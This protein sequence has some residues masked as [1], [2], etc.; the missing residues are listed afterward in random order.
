MVELTTKTL[1]EAGRAVGRL[2]KTIEGDERLDKIAAPVSDF[3]Q[4]LIPPGPV[5]DLLHGTPL[6]HPAHPF[7][8]QVPLGAWMS[9]NVLD[10]LP[11]GWIPATALVGVGTAAA[12][13]AAATGATDFSAANREH[14]R[15]GLIHWASVATAGALYGASFVAR[16]SGNRKAGKRLAL[17]GLA[18]ASVGGYLGGHIAY[19]QA[20]GA[21]H[22]EPVPNLTP[23]GWHDLGL[24]TELPE[25]QLRQ[26]L[27]GN[28]PVVLYRDGD[29]VLA[30]ADACSHLS[31]P[32]HEGELVDEPGIG[33]CVTCPWHG[34]TF[35]LE[36]GAVVH[37][38]ATAPQPQFV[39]RVTGGRVEVMLPGAG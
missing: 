26:R 20:L 29:R 37:G 11:G 30:L 33:A 2:I 19:H 7:L 35:A 23:G 9:A 16:L 3:L 25:H 28:T 12:I 31:G 15:V 38:P 18:A 14:Q 17:A 24:L 27:V 39:A 36:D 4:K 34:S 6:G 10:L 5:R 13:P 32:L 22:T 8:V 21:N 1:T